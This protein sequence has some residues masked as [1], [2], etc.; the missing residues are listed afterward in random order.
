MVCSCS[1]MSFKF[2]SVCFLTQDFGHALLRITVSSGLVSFGLSSSGWLGF[3]AG[4]YS[5]KLFK[6]RRS[7]TKAWTDMFLGLVA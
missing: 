6:W 1:D 2:A 7:S 4:K 5:I 3:G